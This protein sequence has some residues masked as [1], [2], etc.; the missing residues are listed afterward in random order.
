MCIHRDDCRSLV[1]CGVESKART[2]PPNG[3]APTMLPLV[4]SVGANEGWFWLEFKTQPSE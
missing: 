3:A 4:F 2:R 1:E